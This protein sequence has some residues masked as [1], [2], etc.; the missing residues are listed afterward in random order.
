VPVNLCRFAVVLFALSFSSFVYG[1]SA[2]SLDLLN[3]K[4]AESSNTPSDIFEHVPV[5]YGLALECSSVT[6]IGVRS[7]VS[8]WGILKGLSENSHE[9]KSYLGIDLSLPPTKSLKAARRIS[10]DIGITYNFLQAN[11]MTITLDPVELLFIDSLHT[12]CHLT[13]ELEKFSPSVLKYIALHDTSP[14]WDLVDETWYTGDFS[15]YPAHIDKN[16]RGLWPAVE[17]FLATHPEWEIKERRLNCHGFTILKRV[18]D[19][20]MN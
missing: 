18:S 10:K 1:D 14:P 8:T 15:E 3:A 6:E 19:A 5:L 9:G 12:Y 16:K 17:D 13:Y 11:D 4:Y 2:R 20:N 7:M